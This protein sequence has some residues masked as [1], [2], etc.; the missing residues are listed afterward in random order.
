[1]RPFAVEELRLRAAFCIGRKVGALAS[2]PGALFDASLS[3][4]SG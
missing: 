4:N 3:F 1:M 2:G